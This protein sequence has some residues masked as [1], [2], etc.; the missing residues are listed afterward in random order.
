MVKGVGA[1]I[2]AATVLL[3]ASSAGGWASDAKITVLRAK[4]TGAAEKPKGSPTGSGTAVIRL[5]RAT[6]QV[7]W[8]LAVRGIDKPLSSD[9]RK[10][11]PG[12]N[13]PV[14]VP[15]GPHYLATG[16]MKVPRATLAAMAKTPKAYY[17]NVHTRK[18]FDGAIRGQLEHKFAAAHPAAGLG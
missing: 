3:A 6:L 9:I 18:Y 2:A 14:S 4:L 12:K 11:P 17:V 15:L 16:C 7:C 8:R 10:A 13:G 5:N 1:A